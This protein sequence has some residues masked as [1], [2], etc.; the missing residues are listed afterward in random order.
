[1]QVHVQPES[2]KRGAGRQPD[3]VWGVGI[4][5]GAGAGRA[6]GGDSQLCECHVTA[7]RARGRGKCSKL[8][9]SAQS[10]YQNS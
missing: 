3:R 1:M 2:R 4:A 7:P 8:Y 6:A 5:P 9:P 10:T